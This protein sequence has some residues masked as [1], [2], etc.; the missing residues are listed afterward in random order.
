MIA[1]K[2]INTL[3][4]IIIGLVPLA[5]TPPPVSTEVLVIGEGTGAASAAIQ[6]ARSGAS[7]ILFTPSPWLGGML[8]AAGVSATD[9]NHNLP[10]GIWG[11]FR[12]S[13]RKHYGGPDS[14]FT[15][16]VSNTMFEPDVGEYYFQQIASGASGLDIW[17][18]CNWD[19]IKKEKDHWLVSGIKDGQTFKIKAKILI[20]G[21]DLGDVAA[22]V[23]ADYEIGMDPQLETGEEMAPVEGNDIIQDLTYAVILEDFGPDADKTIPKPEGYDPSPFLCSCRETC[24]DPDVEAH[25]CK[26][27]LSYGKLPNGKYMINWPLK[28]ND[29]YTN[30]IDLD[31]TAREKEL[32]KAKNKSLQFVYF[33]QTELGFKHL[34]LAKDIFPTQDHLPLMAYH[35]EGRRIEGLVKL[36]VNHIL[37]PY[38]FKL[39]RTG[40]AVGDYPI[41][42][43]HFERPDAPEIDFP[44][45]PSFCIPMGVLIP[46]NVD[47][48]IM[49]DKAISVTNIVNGSSRLQ[50]VILQIGQVAGLMGAMAAEQNISPKELDI[51]TLQA[52]LLQ[53][54]GYLMPFI[55]VK[56][57]HPNFEAIQKIGSTGLLRGNGIPYK[58]ANQTWFYPD[59]LVAVEDFMYNLEDFDSKIPT[60]NLNGTVL[61]IESAIELIKAW[62]KY[63]GESIDQE[64]VLAQI[65]EKWAKE[66][67][68]EKLELE[69]PILKK[70]LAVLLD[71][72]LDPFSYA[73]VNMQGEF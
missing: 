34:G 70:E 62:E 25:P 68:F 38:N 7:T 33:M 1:T 16:W 15:G 20:D 12:D 32:E 53:E 60:N 36:N 26:T 72:F 2:R 35:R 29:Y 24:D 23:G 17:Y 59:S 13:L 67:Q 14:L 10:A 73:Q 66:W 42:H 56:P 31:R 63:L 71:Y 47:N 57:N 48:L 41:D 5:C 28:G 52:K 45:V 54:N 19:Q 65:N 58:W 49:A 69:R 64:K 18:E 6:S 8:T 46:N 39:Y 3:F 43:H 30:I 27:M 40:I 61:Q 21:T 51:R 50:P 9:G 22:H 11:E 44:P 37:N 4:F 55:D